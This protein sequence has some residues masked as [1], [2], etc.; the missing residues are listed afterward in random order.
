[1]DISYFI[2]DTVPATELLGRVEVVMDYSLR[3][4]SIQI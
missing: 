1:M 4:I 3:M 2:L